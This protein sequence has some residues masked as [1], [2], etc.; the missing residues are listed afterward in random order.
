MNT[1]YGGD[2]GRAQECL[3]RKWKDKLKKVE[4]LASQYRRHPLNSSYKPKLAKPWLP[5]SVWKLFPRQ[6][7]AFNFAK[8]CKEDVHVFSLETIIDGTER[9]LFLVTTYAEFWYYYVN[10]PVSLAH[11]YEVIPADTVCKLY[12]DLEFYKPANPG[13]DGRKMVSLVIEYFSKKLE[14]FYGI[15]CSSECVLNL[16]SSTEEKFSRHLIFVLPD[17]AFKDNIHVGHFIKTVAQPMLSLIA[18][19]DIIAGQSMQGAHETASLPK[20]EDLNGYSIKPSY[21]RPVKEGP[22][23]EEYDLSSLIVKNKYGG[24]Q[25]FID[26]GVYTKNRNF[27]LYKSSKLGKNVPF[28]LAEDNKFKCKPQK[29]IGI[30]EHVFLCSLISNIKFSDSLKILTCTNPENAMNPKPSVNSRN[31]GVTMKGY[32]FSPYPE[33]DDF[34]LSVITREG[35]QGG[36]RSWNYFSAGEI[37]VYETVNYRWCENIGRV[38]KS[39]NVMLLVDLKR[40]VWYQKCYDPL[41][42]VQNFKSHCYPL[43]GE[44]CLPYLFKEENEDCIFTMD[45]NG[46]IQETKLKPNIDAG[47][48]QD[49]LNMPKP[50]EDV[51][52]KER[53]SESEIDDSLILEATED[54]EFV[55]AVDTSL[56]VMDWDELEIPDNLL[57]QS[58]YEHEMFAGK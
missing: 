47:Q 50:G 11:C 45:E 23:T 41:C 58:L 22:S 57:L 10:K 36:I 27:R 2:S 33:I 17:A 51:V 9:R 49:K 19:K 43:P 31:A 52:C 53:C 29:D 13:A 32:Q 20:A 4:E 14:E 7:L 55:D 42:R 54:I 30:E 40:E 1:F 37:V 56:A 38:H 15:K 24:S 6:A 46:N 18:S 3:K 16:D 5:S 44:V 8:T 34:I 25:A 28:E 48:L 21:V 26:Q 12:F 39:N 35:F